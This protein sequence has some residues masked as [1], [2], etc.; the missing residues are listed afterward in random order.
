[1]KSSKSQR[2]QDYFYQY[3]NMYLEKN[4]NIN[5]FLELKDQYQKAYETRTTQ[6]DHLHEEIK[7]IKK[8]NI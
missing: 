2:K 3:M 7:K 5:N 1:M 6:I 4:E 8:F